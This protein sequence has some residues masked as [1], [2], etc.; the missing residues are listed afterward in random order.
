MIIG[1]LG[2]GGSGKTTL[3]T[4]WTKYLLNKSK[5]TE[6][7]VDIVYAIDNDYNMDFKYNLTK[8]Y[9]KND[10]FDDVNQHDLINS[11]KSDTDS[12][13]DI[14]D[15]YDINNMNYIG[16]SLQEIFQEIA[17]TATS[18]MVEFED[19]EFLFSIYPKDKITKK[20]S[21]DLNQKLMLAASGPNT[22]DIMYGA[23]CS[24]SLTTP[25]KVY[26][27]LLQ[28]QKGQFV[29]VDEKAGTDGVGTG[30]T[31]GFNMAVVVA[32]ATEHG[33]KAAKQIIS[34]LSFY[35]TPFVIVI[36]K[37][38]KITDINSLTESFVDYL[39]PFY[40]NTQEIK[41]KIFYFA[42]DEKNIDFELS[43][44]NE[45]EFDKIYKFAN[46]ITD[47]RLKRTKERIQKTKE[48]IN[49]NKS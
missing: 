19:N 20:Y 30:V 16:Q 25:L 1:F 42:L 34:M 23:S 3:A 17:I 24:H 38:R 46:Q 37:I 45:I 49:N 26:L 14:G 43:K 35:N 41:N 10:M 47:N 29:I 39:A 44:D 27:P 48:Y 28:T 31:T 36:N 4:L 2:K 15:G 11:N 12:K 21:V 13:N 5:N 32:E 9:Y 33:I 7:K 22:D 6:D 18:Q 8:L 40:E